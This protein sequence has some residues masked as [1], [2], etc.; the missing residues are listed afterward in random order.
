MSPPPTTRTPSARAG[1]ALPSS[2]TPRSSSSR[3]CFTSRLRR[4]LPSRRRAPPPR[5]PPL[6]PQFLHAQHTLCA[7][8]SSPG[9]ASALGFFS[10]LRRDSGN[11]SG[12]GGGSYSPHSLPG[13]RVWE[14]ERI[15]KEPS[16]LLSRRRAGRAADG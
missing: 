2:S 11:S 13:T 16:S 4:A 10:L 8:A 14:R 1:T 12:G 9:P 6:C 7:L 15:T 3:R 5:L